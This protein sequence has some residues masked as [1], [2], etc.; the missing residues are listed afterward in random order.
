[1]AEDLLSGCPL[2]LWG[3]EYLTP[4]YVDRSSPHHAQTSHRNSCTANLQR[5]D[6]IAT[7][8]RKVDSPVLELS[9]PPI[10]KHDLCL[11][12]SCCGTASTCSSRK[13][14]SLKQKC[15]TI[16]THLLLYLCS[17]LKVMGGWT[18][19]LLEYVLGLSGTFSF[20]QK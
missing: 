7:R 17:L 1:M 14:A 9:C 19:G 18:Q 5:A 20:S 6:F 13:E 8:T 10:S 3:L 4:L 12:A 16:R 11:C 15:A 2:W